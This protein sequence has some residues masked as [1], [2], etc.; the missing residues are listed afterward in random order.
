MSVWASHLKPTRL[1]SLS[2]PGCAIDMTTVLNYIYVVEIGVNYRQTDR[3]C[4]GKNQAYE[5]ARGWAEPKN[6]ALNHMTPPV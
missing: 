3:K 1:K 4:R 5:A 2:V 6:D